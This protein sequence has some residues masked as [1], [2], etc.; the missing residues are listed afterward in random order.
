M[1]TALA[2]LSFGD[3]FIGLHP[4]AARAAGLEPDD[5]SPL[6]WRLD[7]EPAIRAS[8]GAPASPSG[9]P[10]STATRSVMAGSYWRRRSPRC[11]PPSRVWKWD[12]RSV[13]RSA[14]RAAAKTAASRRDGHPSTGC[15]VALIVHAA[16]LARDVHGVDAPWAMPGRS[17]A[18]RGGLFH[19][20]HL[21]ADPT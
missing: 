4:A 15:V 14:K 3:G 19:R 9:A 7:G 13:V 20:H 2:G 21:A 8:G 6:A 5:E 12:G 1:R 17:T 18:A 10:I 11:S 16:R